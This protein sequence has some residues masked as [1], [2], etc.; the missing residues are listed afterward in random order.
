MGHALAGTVYGQVSGPSGV[1]NRNLEVLH[2]GRV[3]DQVRISPDGEYQIFLPKGLYD[4]RV[5]VNH[6]YWAGRL[7]VHSKSSKQN[8]SLSNT[9]KSC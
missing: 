9:G 4:V 6:S 5:C 7:L 3:L 1:T 2:D 8:I